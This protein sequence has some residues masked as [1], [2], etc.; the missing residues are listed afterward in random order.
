MRYEK[1]LLPGL[2][3]LSLIAGCSDLHNTIG[4]EQSINNVPY[5]GEWPEISSAVKKNAVIE[6]KITEILAQMTLEEKVGQMIQPDLREVTPEEAK[7]Y[8]L[9]SLLNGGGG[10]P[11]GNKY[12]T[13]EDWAKES[14]KYWLALDEA[15]KERGFKIPFMWATDAVSF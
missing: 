8:K 12:S 13:A 2:I 3:A 6:R 11:D 5:F 15:Y 9:G 10:W 1:K 7:Q 4:T 14:D